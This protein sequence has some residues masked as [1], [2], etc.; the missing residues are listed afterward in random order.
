MNTHLKIRTVP[1]LLAAA[2]ALPACAQNT[3]LPTP[4][5]QAI[6]DKDTS[7]H[8]GDAPLDA[9]PYATDLSPVLEPAAIDKATGSWRARSHTFPRSGPRA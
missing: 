6:I 5:M 9:G 3:P 4:A 8:F 1:L 2:L 7:R